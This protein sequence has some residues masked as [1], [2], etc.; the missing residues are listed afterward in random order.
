MAKISGRPHGRAA[1][2]LAA[3]AITAALVGTGASAFAAEVGDAPMYGIT[4]VD[5]TGASYYYAPNGE[6]GLQSRVPLDTGWKDINF[7]GL[8]DHNADSIADGRWQTSTSG[9]LSYAANDNSPLKNVGH[10]WGIYNKLVSAGNLGGAEGGDLLG[11]DASGNLFL[12]LGY[13][14]GT[15][16]NRYSVG[17]GWNVYTQIAG[18]GDLTGD[19]KSDLVARDTSGV[20][21]LYKGTGDYKAPFAARTKV[22]AGWNTYNT[23]FA[24][25]D[26]DLDGKADLVGRDAAGAL[27][28]YEGTGSAAAPFG[29]RVKIGTGGWNSY[30]LIF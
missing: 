8:V 25:G 22:G 23:V 26:I 30:R 19:G 17:G 5:S 12:Y 9:D 6:G 21:W 18:N 20:L 13:D 27:Y 24:A 7:L 16:T 15:V 3:A 29:S 10:G 14:D 2:R 4:G 1:T 28:L 11:R